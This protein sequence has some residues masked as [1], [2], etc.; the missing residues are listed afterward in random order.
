MRKYNI[1]NFLD[2]KVSKAE[3]DI[4]IANAKEKAAFR[5]LAIHI[6]VSYIA[7]ALSKCEF[8]TYE[9]GKE[10]K[11]ETYYKLN[12][13]PNPNENSSQFIHHFVENYYYGEKG[14]LIVNHDGGM[15]VADSF[16]LD[17]SNPLKP[18]VYKAVTFGSTAVR[19]PFLR[20]DVV[21]MRLDNN[22]DVKS[23]IEAVDIEYGTVISLAMQ[24]FKR[25]NGKKYK[26]ILDQYQA[27]DPNFKKTYDEVLKGQ[28]KEF[29]ESDGNAIYP[30][31][32][33]IDLQEFSTANPSSSSDI[34]AVRK[35][36]FDVTAQGFHIPLPMMYG[37]ITNMN[38]IVKVFLAFCIDPFADMVSEEF[39]G[40]TYGFEGW[41]KGNYIQVDT[42]RINHVDLFEVA[43][44]VD[45][46]VSSGVCCIDEVRPHLNFN[47][48]NTDFGRA[49]F[50]TKNYD[51]AVDV[52]NGK[53]GGEK[54]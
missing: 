30:K 51:L 12:V 54:E 14:A 32:S 8:K 20:K 21:H 47:P 45:K 17:E 50:I 11:G 15:Y 52:M 4:L 39:T 31:Y 38:E 19:R 40:Q 44:K 5:E 6:A 43:D 46:L 48:L 16:D 26:L 22:H 3:Y 29:I 24:A 53:R 41:A 25:T 42:S 33:G 10:V 18:Y 36:I 28:L 9:N 35:E 34:L 1:F 23:L 37:N 2:K 13:R 7:N 49:H 27:G